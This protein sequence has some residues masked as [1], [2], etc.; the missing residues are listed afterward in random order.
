MGDLDT[1]DKVCRTMC[2]SAGVIV[3]SV[4]YRK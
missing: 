3:V 1:E 2:K 4:D